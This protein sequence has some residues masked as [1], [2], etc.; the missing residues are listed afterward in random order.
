MRI[1]IKQYI[2]MYLKYIVS[3]PNNIYR[4]YPDPYEDHFE[5][6]CKNYVMN[7]HTYVDIRPIL[8]LIFG[9]YKG[10]KIVSANNYYSTFYLS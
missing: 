2:I 5:L 9:Q 7:F 8:E 3:L 4:H 6:I 10:L 1:E